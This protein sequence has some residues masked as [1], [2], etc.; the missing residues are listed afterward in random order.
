MNEYVNSIN[1]VINTLQTLTIPATEDNMGRLL[2][3]LQL[4][5]TLKGELEGKDADNHAE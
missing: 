5:N 2:G 3:C 1:A 4:L